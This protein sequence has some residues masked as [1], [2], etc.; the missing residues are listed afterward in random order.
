[1]RRRAVTPFLAALLTSSPVLAGDS[2][3]PEAGEARPRA[4]VRITTA[5]PLEAAPGQPA[6]PPGTIAGTLIDEDR[7]SMTVLRRGGKDRIRIPRAAIRKLEFGRGSTR[8]RNALIGAGVGAAVGLV[9]AAIEHSRCQGEWL[10]GVEFALP[11][12]TAPAGALVGLATGTQRW[13][14]ASPAAP[15]TLSILPARRGIQVACSV[16]F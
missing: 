7:D 2:P 8:G 14:E 16:T 10:C 4:K 12:L 5:A 13:A 11:I 1:M 6:V 15:L 3:G 9:G